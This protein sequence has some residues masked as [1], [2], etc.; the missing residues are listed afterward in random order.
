MDIVNYLD[1]ALLGGVTIKPLEDIGI[2]CEA[3][4]ALSCAQLG[5]ETI[6]E[7]AVVGNG[8]SDRSHQNRLTSSVTRGKQWQEL[9]EHVLKF[10]GGREIPA[11]NRVIVEKE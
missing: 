5:L 7:L 3:K 1:E 6:L 10:S 8:S 11:V 4:E 2:P 9:Q